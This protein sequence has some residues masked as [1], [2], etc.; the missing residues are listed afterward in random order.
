MVRRTREI[1]DLIIKIYEKLNIGV[2]SKEP[3]KSDSSW[4]FMPVGVKDNVLP[5]PEAALKRLD[6]DHEN[7]RRGINILKNKVEELTKT[8]ENGGGTDEEVKKEIEKT[9]KILND[10]AYPRNKMHRQ[11]YE[12]LKARWEAGDFKDTFKTRREE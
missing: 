10:E 4:Y 9:E 12:E 6:N 3:D 7:L 8:Y 5:L 1:N 2:W 11:Q